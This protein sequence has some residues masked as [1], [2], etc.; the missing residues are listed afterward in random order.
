MVLLRRPSFFYAKKQ[1]AANFWGILFP[2]E[3]V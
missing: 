3:E 1:A 2:N